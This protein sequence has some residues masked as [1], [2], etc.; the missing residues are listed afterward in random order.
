MGHHHSWPHDLIWVH[1]FLRWNAHD[2]WQTA[3][4]RFFPCSACMISA[5]LGR[6]HGG[7]LSDCGSILSWGGVVGMSIYVVAVGWFHLGLLTGTPLGRTSYFCYSC[8]CD[9]GPVEWAPSAWASSL[10]SNWMV[11]W[12]WRPLLPW[13]RPAAPLPIGVPLHFLPDCEVGQGMVVGPSQPNTVMP[14]HRQWYGVIWWVSSPESQTSQW[15]AAGN[16][17]FQSKGAL[18]GGVIIVHPLQPIAGLRH[19]KGGVHLLGK[20]LVVFMAGD[21]YAFPPP[22]HHLHMPGTPLY[23]CQLVQGRGLWIF[24]HWCWWRWQTIF[25]LGA[26]QVWLLLTQELL[27]WGSSGGDSPDLHLLWPGWSQPLPLALTNW[28]LWV[29]PPQSAALVGTAGRTHLFWHHILGSLLL[30]RVLSLWQR[31]PDASVWWD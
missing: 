22:R 21:L 24:G 30:V 8:S 31:S 16:G 20:L 26:K 29:V 1:D 12:P 13:M 6:R 27:R 11:P 9:T 17:I 2:W 3:F 18:A 5:N 15:Q 10:L 7:L 4:H 28:P 14:L 23:Q 25:H 19:L